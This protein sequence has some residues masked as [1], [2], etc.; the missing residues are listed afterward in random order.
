MRACDKAFV[1]RRRLGLSQNEFAQ[2]TGMNN[3]YYKLYEQGR[4]SAPLAD[5]IVAKIYDKNTEK[6]PLTFKEKMS[7]VRRTTDIE[8]IMSKDQFWN[9]YEGRCWNKKDVV[10]KLIKLSN[11]LLTFRDFERGCENKEVSK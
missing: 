10:H 7:I 11:G 6:D 4:L 2:F 5:E 3:N 8:K 9:I 1:I